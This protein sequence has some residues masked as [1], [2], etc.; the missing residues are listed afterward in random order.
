MS[1]AVS[2]D[3]TRISPNGEVELELR[4]WLDSL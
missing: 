3:K 2:V 4:E 1:D